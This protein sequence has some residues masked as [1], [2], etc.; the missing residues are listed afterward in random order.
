[1]ASTNQR[2]KKRAPARK[3]APRNARATPRE[4]RQK[5]RA[6]NATYVAKP[7]IVIPVPWL[8]NALGV[9]LLP[10]CFVSTTTL[11]SSFAS[12]ALDGVFWRSPEF[13]F[14]AV[15]VA[16]WLIAFWG[17]P[18]PTGLYVFGHEMT[19]AL[20][21]YLCGGRIEEFA[22]STKGGHVVTDKNNLL[23]SLSPY[24]VPFYTVLV[25]LLFVIGGAFFDLSRYYDG[26]FFGVAGFRW[27][28]LMFA[29]IGLTWGFHLTFTLWMIAKDQPDLRAHGTFFSVML[30]YLINILLISGLLV[31]ASPAVEASG[32]AGEW[33]ARARGAIEWMGNAVRALSSR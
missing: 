16:L 31:L 8:K 14:F 30:I 3:A 9:L 24:F 7:P 18:R 29:L 20:F 32:F 1:M 28:W 5:L 19:H 11:F 2:R 10:L 33:L 6:R 4:R 27:A 23:I 13:W 26:V 25:L 15:G 12:A 22:F 17:L 21:V